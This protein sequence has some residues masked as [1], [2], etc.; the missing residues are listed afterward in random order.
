MDRS[1]FWKN[2]NL[3]IELDLAGSFIYNGHLL[4]IGN[5]NYLHKTLVV[6]PC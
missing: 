3:G 5:Y 4:F 1:T 6:L 2:F